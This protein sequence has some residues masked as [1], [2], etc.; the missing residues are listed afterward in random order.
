M[1]VQIIHYRQYRLEIGV[2]GP[3]YKVFIYPPGSTFSLP[4]IA[5]TDDKSELDKVVA[6]AERLVDADIETEGG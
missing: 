5:Y 3:G 4:D 2:H 6:E 1:S